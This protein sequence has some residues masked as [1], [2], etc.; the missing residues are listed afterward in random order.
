MSRHGAFSDRLVHHAVGKGVL[1]PGVPL[2]DVEH[3]LEGNDPSSGFGQGRLGGVGPGG[4]PVEPGHVGK[5]DHKAGRGDEGADA[6]A[7]VHGVEVLVPEHDL[8][9][10]LLRVGDGQVLVPG[11][12]LDQGLGLVAHAELRH[13]LGREVVGAAG[14]QRKGEGVAFGHPRVAGRLLQALGL[15]RPLPAV[16]P[17]GLR[18]SLD[19]VGQ[20]VAEP[21]L[22]G[23]DAPDQLQLGSDVSEGEVH[24]LEVLRVDQP[25]LAGLHG[26]RDDV[27]HAD[28]V[29]AEVVAKLIGLQHGFGL[30]R[31]ALSAQ[32]HHRLELRPHVVHTSVLLGV[33]LHMPVAAHLAGVAGLATFEI[34]GLLHV[35]A[36]E[37]LGPFDLSLAEVPARHE[38]RRVQPGNEP[39]GPVHV[40]EGGRA[41]LGDFPP[42]LLA[43][44]LEPRIVFGAHR[45]VAPDRN[46][47]EPLG[48]HHGPDTAPAGE[49]VAGDVDVGEEHAVLAGRSDHRG[50]DL[51]VLQRLLEPGVGLPGPLAPQMVRGA[52]L[53]LPVVDPEVDRGLGRAGDH[54]IVEPGPLQLRA[55]VAS[56]ARFQVQPGRRA[57]G[58]DRDAAGAGGQGAVQGPGADDQAVLGVHGVRPPGDPLVEKLG[59]DASAADIIGGVL[60]GYGFFPDPPGGQ[61]DVEN[62]LLRRATIRHGGPPDAR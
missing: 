8:G 12:L 20:Q 44:R 43:Q 22:P 9:T 15:N 5:S 23:R 17:H 32:G 35:L 57:L 2:P 56:C 4:Q 47:L 46:A 59:V 31:P 60:G 39:R 61:I 21:A 6:Q 42:N 38:A 1:L 14:V 25:L 48:A 26:P 33:E 37:P 7:V 11:D 45:G 29:H 16:A 36:A 55:E 54:Q 58:G 51:W 24:P 41:V 19:A 62:G 27:P 34:A 50:L 18:G 30:G 40:Q 3:A 28:D 52:D 49:V 53:R 13:D 10:L